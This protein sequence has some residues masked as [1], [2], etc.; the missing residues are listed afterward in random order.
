[1]VSRHK[2]S[3]RLI[4]FED[5]IMINLMDEKKQMT[6][7]RLVEL[8][9]LDSISLKV[10]EIAA[11]RLCV[12]MPV[13]EVL[14]AESRDRQERDVLRDESLYQTW[15]ENVDS[16]AT[17]TMCMTTAITSTMTMPIPVAEEEKYCYRIFSF[18]FASEELAVKFKEAIEE[19]VRLFR[20]KNRRNVEI[21]M[22]I[23]SS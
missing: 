9:L 7:K 8:A 22:G 23:A 3:V 16:T 5:C 1:M 11:I 20:I 12:V 17:M 2:Q 18:R 21:A 19:Q 15:N 10:G 14:D 4:L 13:N 6:F